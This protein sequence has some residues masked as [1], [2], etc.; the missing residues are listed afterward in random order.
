MDQFILT[1]VGQAADI[2]TI[3]MFVDYLMRLP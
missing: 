3:I 2:F 1:L